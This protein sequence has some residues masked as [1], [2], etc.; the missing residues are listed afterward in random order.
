M[1]T[2]THRILSLNSESTVTHLKSYQA[3]LTTT[4]T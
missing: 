1:T 3:D 4:E 2:G